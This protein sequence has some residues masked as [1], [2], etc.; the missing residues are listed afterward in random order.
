MP[1]SAHAVT[2]DDRFGQALELA[3]TGR[4]AELRRDLSSALH[5]YGRA[6]AL[7]ADAAASPLHANLLRWRGSVLRDVGR[8]DE[9]DRLY[10]ESYRVAD[11]T[12]SLGAMASA[13]NCSA[14]IAQRRGQVVDAIELY[15]RADRLATKAGDLRL[16]GMIQQ[17]LGVL[18]NIRGELD[19]A[20]TRYRGAL[21]A[22]EEL[23]DDEPVSWVLNNIGMLLTDLGLHH[24][25][26][27]A[28]VRGLGIAGGTGAQVG[29]E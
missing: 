14:V 9:A 21:K 29:F 23:G 5:H 4:A 15:R 25:A 6:H 16:V 26:E 12:G 3:R 11:A 18:A 10:T 22:F 2:T 24:R 20:L 27:E 8:I 17:N 7:I 19:E 1:M 28:F 13:L